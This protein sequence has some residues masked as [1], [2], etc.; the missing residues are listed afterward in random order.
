MIKRWTN[1]IRGPKP[2][3]DS[4]RFQPHVHLC[5][6]AENRYVAIARIAKE[7]LYN[8]G[9]VNEDIVGVVYNNKLR[10][11]VDTQDNW[12]TVSIHNMESLRTISKRE[13]Y[14]YAFFND[15]HP[16]GTSQYISGAVLYTD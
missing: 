2:Q 13:P 11:F 10:P 15:F 3:I 14:A 4:V 16:I 8:V 1:R 9:V 6:M 5:A 7:G 12:V